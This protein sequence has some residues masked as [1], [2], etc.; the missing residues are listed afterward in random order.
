MNSNSR[1][2]N[3]FM[4]ERGFENLGGRYDAESMKQKFLGL[5]GENREILG[6][7]MN[8]IG[9]SID[10][11][12]NYDFDGTEDPETG[13]RLS[14]YLGSMA[15]HDNNRTVKEEYAQE[16]VQYLESIFNLEV[17]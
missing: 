9:L 5:S 2:N 7:A 4:S 13:E 1:Y 6:V 10:T 11:L 17:A 8:Q 12:D 3:Y 15:M 14:D 16:L